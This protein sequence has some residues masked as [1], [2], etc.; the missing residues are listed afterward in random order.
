MWFF[1]QDSLPCVDCNKG[2]AILLESPWRVAV[3]PSGNG[4]LF[5]A[6]HTQGCLG[7]LS[8]QGVRYI[9]VHS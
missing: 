1:K 5:S 2:H 3:A 6:L 8:E 9:Q 7:R 4:G